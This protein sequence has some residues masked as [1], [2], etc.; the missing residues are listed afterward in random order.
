MKVSITEGSLQFD[1]DHVR[2]VRK[3]DG[4]SAYVRGIRRLATSSAADFLV[5]L[6]ADSTPVILEVTDYRG[7]RLGQGGSRAAL[8]SGDLINEVVSKV[9]DSVAGLLW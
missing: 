7:Y 2:M 3:W 9:R 5:I 8:T 4:S 1:F 6:E